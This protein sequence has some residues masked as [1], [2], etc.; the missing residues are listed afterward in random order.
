MGR[1]TLDSPGIIGWDFALHK[2][3]PFNERHK[4]Q[5]RFEAF[6]FPNHP[7]WNNPNTN[8]ASGASFG[9]IT[10]TRN[11]MRNL[12]FALKHIF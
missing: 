9:Q 3:F 10:S 12:Q 2:E 4:M 8:I 6:N 11:N 5:F 7:N 1:G